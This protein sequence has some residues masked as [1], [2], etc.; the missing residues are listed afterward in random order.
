[1]S[2]ARWPRLLLIAAFLLGVAAWYFVRGEKQ[3]AIAP[4]R[5]PAP[6]ATG[7]GPKPADPATALMPGE[8]MVA[9]TT[10]IGMSPLFLVAAGV[11]TELG[12][13]LSHAAIVAREYNVP[14]ELNVDGVTLS[15]RTGERLRVDGDRG[16]VEKL[17]A[18]QKGPSL[19]GAQPVAE[20]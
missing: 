10:D 2:E 16:V 7:T 20:P 5:P 12:G 1:M 17:D 9:R 13:P 4:A 14:A 11:V 8:I 6:V 3:P 15:V 18:P 19:V